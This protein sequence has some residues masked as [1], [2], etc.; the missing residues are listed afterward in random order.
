M[1]TSY[2]KRSAKFCF[3]GFLDSFSDPYVRHFLSCF[4]LKS[5]EHELQF[6]RVER[7]YNSMRKCN[8]MNFSNEKCVWFHVETTLKE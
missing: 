6:I 5:K 3:L 1:Q 4:D 2:V 8:F 7:L